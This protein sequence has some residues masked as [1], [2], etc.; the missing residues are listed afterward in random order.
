MFHAK[1]PR[2]KEAAKHLKNIFYLRTNYKKNPFSSDITNFCSMKK[3]LILLIFMPLVSFG[4]F[5]KGTKFIGGTTFY[6]SDTDKSQGG[7]PPPTTNFLLE[8]QVGFFL[9]ESLAVGP[10]LGAYVNSYASINPATN[11]YE[12]KKYSGFSGGVIARKFYPLTDDFLFSLEGKAIVGNVN[13]EETYYQSESRDTRFLFAF[14]PVLTFM[15]HQRWAL[16]AGIGEISYS[17][18]GSATTDRDTFSANFG[19]VRLGVNYFFNR[20]VEQ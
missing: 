3:L 19:L 4:Q 5:S 10:V 14:R 20:A 1:A 13:R 11:L 18:N 15:P 16:D 7:S 6:T 9:N 17:I 8:G 2:R 12:K